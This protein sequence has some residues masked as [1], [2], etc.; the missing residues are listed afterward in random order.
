MDISLRIAHTKG[1]NV[2]PMAVLIY[3]PCF[4]YFL[5]SDLFLLQLPDVLPGEILVQEDHYK[6]KQKDEKEVCKK[7]SCCEIYI[8]I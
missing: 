5:G 1:L 4:P 6:N 3:Q 8:Y 2:N 7:V